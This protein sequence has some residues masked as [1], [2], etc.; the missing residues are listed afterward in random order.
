VSDLTETEWVRSQRWFT[1]AKRTWWVA[2]VNELERRVIK[3]NSPASPTTFRK[4]DDGSVT[5]VHPDAQMHLRLVGGLVMMDGRTREKR[6]PEHGLIKF[7]QDRHGN[8]L[9]T[10]DESP[11]TSPSAAVEHA[12]GVMSA[13]IKEP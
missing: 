4:G 12:L 2:F 10:L 3:R 7:T 13:V 5:V 6:L 11:L 8:L 1:A 9:A